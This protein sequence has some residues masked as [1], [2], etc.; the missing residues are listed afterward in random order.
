VSREELIATYLADLPAGREEAAAEAFAIGQTIGT[1]LAVPGITDAMRAAH[2]GRVEGLR[3]GEPGERVL[4]EAADAAWILEVAFPTANFGPQFP[5]LFT[6]LLGNDPSTSIRCR[7]VALDLPASF[8]G[9]FP[10]PRHGADGWRRLT[11]VQ[12]RPLLLN[13]IKPCTG[14]PPDIGAAFV[15]EVALGG[16]DLV[17]DDEL[18]ADPGFAPVA[19]RAAAYRAA[20]DEV[21]DATGHRARYVANVTTRVNALVGTAEA[22][23]DGGADA[24]MVNVFAI[25]LDGLAILAE[26]SLGAPILAH[27]AGVETLAGSGRAGYGQAVLLGDLV[28]LAGGDAI[29]LSTPYASHPLDRAVYVES[30]GRMRRPWDRILA[31]MPVVGGGLTAA[32]V[33]SLLDDLGS[34]AILAVGGAIQ[35]HPDGATVGAAAIRK[36][37][38][39]ASRWAAG[40]GS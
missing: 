7:L 34:D 16:V 14:Y 2:G 11:G 21:A 13:M 37:I 30:V 20:L 4:G 5:M 8:A 9:A 32:H 24:L 23:L 3:R 27:S 19:V 6:T 26:A 12:D 31:A 18:L 1:W 40:V 25:G 39:A 10:G 36:A 17:K 29:L 28:R 35:G 22:A 38:E 33:R 15:R